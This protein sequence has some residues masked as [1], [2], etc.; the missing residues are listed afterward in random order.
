MRYQVART[1]VSFS[2]GE[3]DYALFD[4]YDG[5]QKPAHIQGVRVQGADGKS[6]ELMCAGKAVSQLPALEKIIPC[7]AENA[8]ASCN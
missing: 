1:E 2:I 3:Y 8:L 5:E 4:H 6:T 7:D